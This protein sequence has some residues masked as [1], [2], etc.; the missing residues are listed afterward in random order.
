MDRSVFFCRHPPPPPL[1]HAHSNRHTHPSPATHIALSCARGTRRSAPRQP[2]R[3][4]ALHPKITTKRRCPPP[5]HP[6]RNKTFCIPDGGRCWSI[7]H[8]GNR[9]DW[10]C[11]TVFMAPFAAAQPRFATRSR[12]PSTR[13]PQSHPACAGQPPRPPEEGSPA[14]LVLRG[15]ASAARATLGIDTL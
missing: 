15:P 9:P 1:R 10:H 8:E 6:R 3:T 4:R 7:S 5:A 2:R 14:T 12:Q 13:A 11:Q